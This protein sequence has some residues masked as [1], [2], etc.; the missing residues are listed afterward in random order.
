MSFTPASC[1]DSLAQRTTR[2]QSAPISSNDRSRPTDRT[3]EPMSGVAATQFGARIPEQVSLAGLSINEQVKA[4]MAARN[5]F[6][7]QIS[8]RKVFQ[9]RC[10]RINTFYNELRRMGYQVETVSTFGL[11]HARALLASWRQRDLSK[12]TIY[13]RWGDLRTWTLALNKHGMLGSIEEF[14]PDFNAASTASKQYRTFTAEQ[15]RERSEFLRAASDQTAYFVDRL[16]REVGMVRQEALEMELPAAAGIA[17]G[18]GLLRCGH[19]ASART[20]KDMAQHQPLFAELVA[21]MSSRNR[22]TL[23]W[24]DMPIDEAIQKFADRMVYVNRKLFPKDGAQS[25]GDK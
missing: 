11:K 9:D 14:W 1:L 25:R 5:R 8:S 19:G 7:G 21:F 4:V 23:G 10:E 3:E 6:L 17:S 20:Y 15:I 18:N 2:P 16:S 22:K 12:K 24:T 13:N